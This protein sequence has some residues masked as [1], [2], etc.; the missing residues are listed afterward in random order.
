MARKVFMSV[1]GNGLYSKC[2]YIKDEFVSTE[3]RFVQQATLQML[4]YS[5]EKWTENDCAY[6]LLTEEAR[7]TNWQVDGNKRKKMMEISKII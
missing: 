4:N 1:I 2:I 6:F 7:K 5:G 3:T